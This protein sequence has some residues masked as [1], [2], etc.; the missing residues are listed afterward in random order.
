[1]NIALYVHYAC[2][3]CVY[4]SICVW[5]V[6]IGTTEQR[7]CQTCSEVDRCKWPTAAI[8]DATGKDRQAANISLSLPLA[9]SP[10]HKMICHSEQECALQ[11]GRWH[12][13]IS[14]GL[15]QNI[16]SP[17]GREQIK[18]TRGQMESRKEKVR[19]GEQRGKKQTYFANLFNQVNWY[20]HWNVQ[21]PNRLKKPENH[22]LQAAA[23]TGLLS[24]F[25]P[26][27]CTPQCK[28]PF[29]CIP[30]WASSATT[31][32]PPALIIYLPSIYLS[33]PRPL[34]PPSRPPFFKL[35]SF[36]LCYSPSLPL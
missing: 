24:P 26:S 5:F 7:R 21:G 25:L 34:L 2:V 22:H 16:V 36:I 19:E 12:Q 17:S 15:I 31:S 33:L 11:G 13:F 14:A 35:V 30:L 1:M 32:P 4:L 27:A 28:S 18:Q 10:W 6:R 8:A 23:E 3:A 29:Y 9:H 20:I